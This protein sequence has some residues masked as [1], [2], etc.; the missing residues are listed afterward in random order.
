MTYKEFIDITKE[1]FE[2]RFQ[3]FEDRIK[4]GLFTFESSIPYS[5]PYILKTAETPTQFLVEF[6]GSFDIKTNDGYKIKILDKPQKLT[7]ASF[8]INPGI[9]KENYTGVHIINNVKEVTIADCTLATP[10]N[11]DLYKKKINF[12]LIPSTLSS[13]TNADTLIKV[14]LNSD[15]LTLSDLD[16]VIYK[17]FRIFFKRITLLFLIKKSTS[18]AEYKSWLELEWTRR[19]VSTSRVLGMNY[20]YKPSIDNFAKD[21]FG[22]T[23]Q[24]TEENIIDRFLLYNANLFCK[25]LGMDDIIYKPKL[26]LINKKGF[27]NTDEYLIPD[28]LLK[29]PDGFYD[30]LDLK[31]SLI[32]EISLTKGSKK[33]IQF[34]RFV[35]ELIAQLKGYE[36]YFKHP[37]NMKAANKMGIYVQD[38]KLYGIIGNQN[39]FI[40]EDIELAKESYKD[41]IILLSYSD[42]IELLKTRN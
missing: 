23:N 6:L 26:P 14:D 25:S 31:K 4:K 19:I 30:I 7:E 39:N 18:I 34:K 38:L 42:V 35:T 32:H 29:R 9:V 11:I 22:L 24:N 27:N 15:K 28:Y 3:D 37:D 20:G 17:N 5:Y 1:F 2:F 40:K 8:F 13:N 33:R 12:D 21:L 10:F 36:R 16:L 41:N